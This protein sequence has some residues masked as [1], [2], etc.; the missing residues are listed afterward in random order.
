[1]FSANFS[2][3]YVKILLIAGDRELPIAMSSF[4]FEELVVNFKVWFIDTPPITPW[5]HPPPELDVL[6][7]CHLP[8]ICF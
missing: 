2:K 1:V 4:L 6:P 5:W 7:L 8:A 3:Y